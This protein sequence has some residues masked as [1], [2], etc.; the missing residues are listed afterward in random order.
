VN[1]HRVPFQQFVDGEPKS[2]I[3]LAYQRSGSSFFGQM[4][5]TNPST[6]FMFEPLDALYSATYG[7]SA[8]WNV[9]TD[10]TAF[11]NGSQR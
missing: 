9:P 11:R 6:F 10:I 5:N 3:I 2:V 4:F 1:D 7:T 8:G